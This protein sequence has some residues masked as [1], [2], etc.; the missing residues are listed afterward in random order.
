MR[1]AAQTPDPTRRSGPEIAFPAS[2]QIP[3][4]KPNLYSVMPSDAAATDA[5]KRREIVSH[6]YCKTPEALS[7]LTDSQYRVGRHRAG[8]PQRVLG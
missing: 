5:R 2:S 4:T 8:V 3:G 1:K 7:R 6:D